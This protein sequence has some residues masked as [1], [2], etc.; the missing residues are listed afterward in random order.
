M[1]LPISLETTYDDE[2]IYAI[3]FIFFSIYFDKL[4]HM[5]IYSTHTIF[6]VFNFSTYYFIVF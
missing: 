5:Y 1:G 2:F 3:Y 6:L 4:I